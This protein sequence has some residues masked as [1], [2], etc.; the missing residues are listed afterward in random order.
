MNILW[1]SKLKGNLVILQVGIFSTLDHS[2]A[3]TWQVPPFLGC[4][5]PFPVTSLP[6]SRTFSLVFPHFSLSLPRKYPPP[7]APSHISLTSLLCNSLLLHSQSPH[8]HTHICKHTTATTI[9][10]PL[11][12]FPQISQAL[13][14]SDFSPSVQRNT[15]A[16]PCHTPASFLNLR[17]R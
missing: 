14:F 7:S 1:N 3:D 9:S 16:S 17:P 11:F 13:S 10:L 8:T 4:S 6:F 2:Q 12:F 5:F 15:L